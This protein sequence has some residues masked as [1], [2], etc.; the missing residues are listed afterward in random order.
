M[1]SK[2]S[3]VILLIFEILGCIEEYALASLFQTVMN[4]TVS[5]RWVRWIE[6]A[7]SLRASRVTT[8]R[9]G[10]NR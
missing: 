9:R 7:D 10:L 3:F 6:P 8:S 4:E 2:E 5:N 1:S